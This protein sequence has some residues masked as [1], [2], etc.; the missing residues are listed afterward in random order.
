MREQLA[1]IKE[2]GNRTSFNTADEICRRVDFLKGYLSNSG[3]EL[4]L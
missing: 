2:L 3:G 1:I 4:W